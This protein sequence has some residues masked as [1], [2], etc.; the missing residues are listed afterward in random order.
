MA[1]LIGGFLERRL[2]AHALSD[3]DGVR[4]D[5]RLGLMVYH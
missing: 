4:Y 2:L 1:L 5:M 3:I